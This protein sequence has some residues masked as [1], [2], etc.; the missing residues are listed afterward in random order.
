MADI[1][2]SI[3]TVCFNCEGYIERTIKSVIRQTYPSVQYIVIDGGSTDGTLDIIEKY[4]ERIDVLISEKD[5]GIYD[6]MNKGL[7]Y[8][9]GDLVY[10]LNAGDYLCDNYVLRNVAES[11]RSSPGSDILYGD[12][13]YYD[14][15]AEERCSGYRTGISDLISK[16]YCHQTTFAKRSIFDKCGNFNAGYRIYAD[17]DWLLRALSASGHRMRYI[18]IPVVYYLKGGESESRI[19]RCYPEKVRIIRKNMGIRGLT[20]LVIS[21][22]SISCRYL[23]KRFNGRRKVTKNMR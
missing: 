19:V 17:F 14:D 12:Y 4:K 21:F 8:A 5:D 2:I 15:T 1:K 3:I 9:T 10:F 23:L 6:A 18:G 20:S 13:I 22:P 16:G 11:L 7:E